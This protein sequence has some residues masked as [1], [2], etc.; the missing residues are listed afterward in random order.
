[1]GQHGSARLTVHDRDPGRRTGLDGHGGCPRCGRE[2]S[3]RVQVGRSVP[4]RG[5]GGPAGGSSVELALQVAVARVH[6]DRLALV[7]RRQ[8]LDGVGDAT[9]EQHE[10]VVAPGRL[11][12]HRFRGGPVALGIGRAA[13]DEGLD[14]LQGPG[15]RP[16]GF[17]GSAGSR[18]PRSRSEVAGRAP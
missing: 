6:L 2:P 18:C 15:P 8:A 7:L 1:M 4:H 17:R 9:V 11:R 3:D 16:S 12:L 14:V 13:G 10:A 5:P